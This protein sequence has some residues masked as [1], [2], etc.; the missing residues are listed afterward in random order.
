MLTA[1]FWVLLKVGAGSD[2]S[3][4]TAFAATLHGFAPAILLIDHRPGRLQRMGITLPYLTVTRRELAVRGVPASSVT[5]IPDQAGTD[6]DRAR[7]LRDWLEQ[8]PAARIAVLCNRFGG[9][10]LRYILDTILGAE[11][12][13]RVRLLG[14]PERSYD[15][16]DWWQHR[17]AIVDVFDSY[18][19]LTFTRLSGEDH[20]KW[21]EWDPKEYE[22]TLR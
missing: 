17:Q 22:K 20:E 16:H 6:W 1:L 10:K 7:C 3:F 14:L 5:V 12:A 18:L 11:A 8:H 21:R 9:R 15:E 19:N 4:R 2:W 13:G